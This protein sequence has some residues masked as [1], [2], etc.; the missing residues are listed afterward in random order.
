[1]A[2][3]TSYPPVPA[4]CCNTAVWLVWSSI[5]K[6]GWL[7]FWWLLGIAWWGWGRGLLRLRTT[8]SRSFRTGWL[9]RNGL[10]ECELGDP[11]ASLPLLNNANSC[12]E[13]YPES[14]NSHGDGSSKS[15][16]E[17]GNYPTTTFE[18]NREISVTSA[19]SRLPPLTSNYSP[20]Y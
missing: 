2:Q 17:R 10:I 13:K 3:S 1:M 5:D 11:V 18:K 14:G 6:G 4:W 9:R 15:R 7:G 16:D 12:D 19:R 8:R 20:G